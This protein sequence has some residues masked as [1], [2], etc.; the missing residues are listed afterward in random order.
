MRYMGSA[1]IVVGGG[2]GGLSAALA[3]HRIG[4]RVT[5]LESAPEFGEVGA[6]LT[7]MTN[8]LRGPLSS[9]VKGRVAVLG[10]A[11]HAMTPNL[12]QGAG[13]AI[14]DAVVLGEVCAGATE[15]STALE[16]YDKHRRPRTQRISRAAYRASRFGQQLHHPLAVAFRNAA[17]RL[18]PV[19]VSS[20]WMAGIV[21][22]QPP[23]RDRAGGHAP[24][25]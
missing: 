24:G 20:R 6:G 18:T 10:D 3:L 25:T 11:A 16:A 9:Y 4:W 5:V 12:G 14:E 7:L 23:R 1:A 22:W 17:L 15:L 21:D 2:I 13:Q 8:G 19:R